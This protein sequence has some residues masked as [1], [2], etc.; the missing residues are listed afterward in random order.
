MVLLDVQL[1]DGEGVELLGRLLE[2]DPDLPVILITGGRDIERAMQAIAAGAFDW[3][4]KP[5]EP[6]ELERLV[7]RAHAARQATAADGAET[8]DDAGADPGG[9]E[10]GAAGNR[11]NPGSGGAQRYRG[12]DHR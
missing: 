8:D 2:I 12:V 4:S 9:R 11:Q 5:F 1:P 6:A 3:L 10:S 7:D